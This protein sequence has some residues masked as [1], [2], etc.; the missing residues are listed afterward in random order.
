MGQALCDPRLILLGLAGLGSGCALY[1]INLWLPQIIHAMGFSN[2]ATGFVAALPYVV[3]MVDMIVRV[4]FSDEGTSASGMRA[5]AAPVRAAS[6]SRE[7]SLPCGLNVFPFSMPTCRMSESFKRREHIRGLFAHNVGE[8]LKKREIVR[9]DRVDGLA[10]AIEEGHVRRRGFP[11]QRI[12]FQLLLINE[13]AWW[14]FPS[15]LKPRMKMK[16]V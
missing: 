11:G 7:G 14:V 10:R 5:N 4:L 13:T 8:R 3:S 2:R 12:H 1:G 16:T 9:M 6:D 15:T